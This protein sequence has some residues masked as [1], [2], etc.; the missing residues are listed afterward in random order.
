MSN[1]A[2]S[3]CNF[4]KAAAWLD[5]LEDVARLSH[6]ANLPGAHKEKRIISRALGAADDLLF[7]DVVHL[8]I[9][10]RKKGVRLLGYGFCGL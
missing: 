1:L 8:L 9:R 10:R 2:E 5:E 6:Q 7:L 4:A 3:E